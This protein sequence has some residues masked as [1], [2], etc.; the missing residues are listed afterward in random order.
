M[1]APFEIQTD[2][3]VL[4]TRPT[5]E[6]RGGLQGAPTWLYNLHVLWHSR[7]VL[8]RVAVIAFVV[9]AAVA[10]LV[11]KMYTSQARIMPPETNSSN[12]AMLA[13]LAQRATGNDMLG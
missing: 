1:S 7:S 6:A 5:A 4:E 9:S 11:P 8:M 13:A 3:A 2:A 12:P 10:M